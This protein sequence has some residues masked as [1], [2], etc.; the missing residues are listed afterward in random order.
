MFNKTDM[1]MTDLL[2][3]YISRKDLA[4]TLGYTERTLINWGLDHKGP[5]STKIGRRVMY[6]RPTVERWLRSQERAAQASTNAT[7]A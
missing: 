1:A 5:P 7:A 3:D 6:F 2:Q 4:D